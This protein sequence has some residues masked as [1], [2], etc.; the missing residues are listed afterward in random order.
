[1]KN[2]K[3][4]YHK[5]KTPSSLINFRWFKIVNLLLLS[6]LLLMGLMNL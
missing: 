6:A 2:L 4:N 5:A 1:M 3:L